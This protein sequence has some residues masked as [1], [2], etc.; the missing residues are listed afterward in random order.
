MNTFVHF[1][2]SITSIQVQSCIRKYKKLAITKPMVSMGLGSSLGI[3]SIEVDRD[4]L[5][6]L[7]H[8]DHYITVMHSHAQ[9]R[10]SR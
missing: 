5:W 3:I 6:I 2:C 4:L 9:L 7:D 10:V 8:L 1:Y